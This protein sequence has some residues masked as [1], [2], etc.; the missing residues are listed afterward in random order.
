MNWVFLG[1][2]V[3]AIA[4]LMLIIFGFIEK[5]REG[6][7]K[8]EQTQIDIKRLE[9]QLAESEKARVE[10]ETR[11]AK[12]EEESLEIEQ[13]VSELHHKINSVLPSGAKM[14]TS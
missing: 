4:Y 1:I 13:K 12:L 2:I 11:T 7:G 9:T 3:G 6:R 5:H 10:A 14:P 8:I